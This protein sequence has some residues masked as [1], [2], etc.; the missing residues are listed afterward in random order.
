MLPILRERAASE[1]RL[2]G[3]KAEANALEALAKKRFPDQ[4]RPA[5]TTI[6]KHL[7]GVYRWIAVNG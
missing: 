7:A 6:C 5:F 1:M 2:K 4:P 3:S